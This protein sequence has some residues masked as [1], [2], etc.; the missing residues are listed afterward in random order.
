LAEAGLTDTS[1]IEN[2]ALPAVVW[3]TSSGVGFDRNSWQ[4][5]AEAARAESERL[6][7]ELDRAAPPRSQGEMF[8]SGWKWDSPQHVAEAL[9]AVGHV[10][11]D[12]HDNTL[13]TIDHPLAA[14]LRDYRAAQKLASTYGVKWLKE[15]YRDG[16]IFAGWRQLGANSGR[17]ACSSP[18]LQNLPR[19]TRYRRCFLTA[20]VTARVLQ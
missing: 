7:S 5:L 8:G 14:L 2:R 9:Q 17:M 3:L 6:A 4:A 15:S 11:E 19:D 16:R 13:A 18:N 12:T 20:P 10:V 1:D